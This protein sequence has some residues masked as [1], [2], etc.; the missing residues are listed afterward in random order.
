[1]HEAASQRDSIKKRK[2]AMIK[3]SLLL[4][5]CFWFFG[6][7]S[8]TWADTLVSSSESHSIEW[9]SNRG[10]WQDTFATTGARTP[11]GLAV[12]P[13]NGDVYVATF[14]GTI[15]RYHSNERP[16]ANWDTFNIPFDGNVVESLLFDKSGN[17]WV[18][19]Y[20]G[21]SGY[22]ANLYKYSAASLKQP[23]PAPVDTIP[24]GLRRGNQM[25]FDRLGDLCIASFLNETVRCFDLNTHMQ[26]FDY[27]AEL[28]G[29]EP[30]GIAFDGGNHLYVANV[31]TGQV[32]KEQTPH[33]GPF[34]IL[35]QSLTAE[36][37]FL[38]MRSTGLY[39]PSFHNADAR[40]SGCILGT[41]AAAYACNDY[42][43]TSDTVYNIDPITG[44]V[45]TFLST[46]AW[47]P[48]QSVAA[49]V[50]K[51]RH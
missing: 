26:A 14:T 34:N 19:T 1:M 7:F 30:A 15:L 48:Y 40:L 27:G 25:A 24:T 8:L 11:L 5:G 38:A 12:S 29:I 45:T 31:F 43:F 35:A 46:H 44:A 6:L 23:N 20:F 21:E 37:E 39:V 17:L 50:T 4:T 42:D 2:P 13:V 3:K 9:F 32:L 51:C 18:A 16:T 41:G 36:I 28:T 47:G 22:V 33:A 10:V 49:T